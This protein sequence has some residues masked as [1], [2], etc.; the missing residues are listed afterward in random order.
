MGN[1]LGIMKAHVEF[2]LKHNEIREDFKN[3]LKSLINKI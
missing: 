2:A 1:K 3:Y